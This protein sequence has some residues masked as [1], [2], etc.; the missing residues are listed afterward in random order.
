MVQFPGCRSHASP[1]AAGI[2]IPY[3]AASY[4]FLGKLVDSTA[5]RLAFPARRKTLKNRS[6]L[7]LLS[8]FADQVACILFVTKSHELRVP[9]V[10]AVG[11]FCVFALRGQ[12]GL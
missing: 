7:G 1:L 8:K 2:A 9:Q 11:P 6:R 3:E 4:V 5:K 12:P 10:V